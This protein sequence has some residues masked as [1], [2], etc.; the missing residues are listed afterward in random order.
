MIDE[1]P[2]AINI[3]VTLKL[4]NEKFQLDDRVFT[5]LAESPLKHRP[6]VAPLSLYWQHEY[7]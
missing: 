7:E 2:T 4:Q 1:S 6:L 3:M 5:Q